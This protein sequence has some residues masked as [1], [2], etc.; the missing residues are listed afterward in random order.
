MEGRRLELVKEFKYLD[1]TWT[2]K[3]S[4]KP[5]ID[6]TIEN[7]QRAFCKLKWL[8]GGKALSTDVSRRC[9]FAYSYSHFA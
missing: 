8:K 4:L 1:F 6:K 2:N 9:F 3:M 7:I 5:T